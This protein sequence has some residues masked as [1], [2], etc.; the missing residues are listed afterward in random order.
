VTNGLEARGNTALSFGPFLITRVGLIVKRK[1]TEAEWAELFGRLDGVEDAYRWAFGDALRAVEVE[2]G[3]AAAQ[4]TAA[5]PEYE[6]D[7]LRQYRWVADKVEFVLR[8]T[9]LSWS[10][11]YQVG[12][13]EPKEQ[14]KWLTT[15]EAM[16]W[17]VR[18]LRAALREGAPAEIPELPPGKFA[19]IVVDPPWP[20]GTSYDQEGRR[21]ASPYPEMSLEEIAGIP[22]PAGD[23]CMLWLWTTHAF[24]RHAFGL[25]DQWEFQEKA[26]LTW[27]KDRMGLGQWLRS[28]SEF[29]IMAVKGKPQITLTSQTTVVAGKLREHSR[30][31]DE[32]YALVESLCP[33][34]K[35]DYFSREKREGWAQVGN[36]PNKF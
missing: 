4:M 28:Q 23:D 1:P 10:H 32:F 16:G 11:H 20:Y 3:E 6:Y 15:A 36:E 29:C 33:G 25:L 9:N 17:T 30:K 26:I 19:V 13:L 22:L 8:N 18:E 2:Y 24:M 27:V 31:P 7:A 34:R 21:A 35:L 14:K 12:R 5:Y